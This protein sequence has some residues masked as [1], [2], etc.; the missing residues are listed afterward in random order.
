MT[1]VF[2]AVPDIS[3]S[4]MVKCWECVSKVRVRV[5]AIYTFMFQ[6]CDVQAF[7]R[8]LLQAPS[9]IEVV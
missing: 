1:H 5:C 9:L 2:F 8:A 4:S 6:S 7:F 3:R